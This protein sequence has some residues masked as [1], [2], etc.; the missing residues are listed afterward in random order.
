MARVCILLACKG[1]LNHLTPSFI[2]DVSTQAKFFMVLT[3]KSPVTPIEE[4][5]PS[6]VIRSFSDRGGTMAPSLASRVFDE[7]ALVE[8]IQGILEKVG[9][10]DE[11]RIFT[12]SEMM[13]EQAARVRIRFN[14]QGIL[15]LFHSFF[16][17]P[18]SATSSLS[19]LSSLSS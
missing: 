15:S 17:F 5:Y 2:D 10:Y 19:S 13:L 9:E 7:E 12:S 6:L 3:D 14:A 1:V 18:T 11:L 4:Q 16:F 8:T